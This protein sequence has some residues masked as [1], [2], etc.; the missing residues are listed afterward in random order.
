MMLGFAAGAASAA[1]TAET[2]ASV[3][4]QRREN[5]NE[6]GNRV[7]AMRANEQ[8]RRA[9]SNPRIAEAGQGLRPALSVYV[10][11]TANHPKGGS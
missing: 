4:K 6:T 3:S 1:R 9:T 5:T 8:N 7:E 2:A 10:T 11:S